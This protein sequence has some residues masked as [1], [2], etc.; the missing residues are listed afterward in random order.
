MKVLIEV[1]LGS[2]LKYKYCKES[3]R[4]ILDKILHNTNVFPFNYGFIQ[5]TL[6][7]N[8]NPLEAIVICNYSLL[9]GSFIDCK[10]LGGIVTTDEN[11]LD[12]KIILIPSDSIDPGSKYY[13]SL[14][15][16]NKNILEEISYFL[17]HYK[18]K[19]NGKYIIV[20]DYYNRDEALRRINKYTLDN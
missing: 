10:V 13:N 12:D 2:N 16:L 15:N 17:A 20:K 18:D 1:S 19:E 11:G 3:K 8:G 14:E 9:P 5:K 6:S 4:M 7:P